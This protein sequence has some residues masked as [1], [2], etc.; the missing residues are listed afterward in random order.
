M[1]QDTILYN[2]TPS[3][4]YQYLPAL[5]HF[6]NPP[7]QPLLLEN[8]Q[9]EAELVD[10]GAEQPKHDKELWE[11]TFDTI[12]RYHSTALLYINYKTT[13][14]KVVHFIGK[15]KPW[16]LSSNVSGVHREVESLD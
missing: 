12:G 6:Q 15:Y 11:S 8:P 2:V 3:A 1:D 4:E 7:G 5:K 9:A 13:Q 10:Q 14:V 16:R